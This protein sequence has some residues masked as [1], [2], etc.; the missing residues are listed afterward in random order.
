MKH[1]LF[2]IACLVCLIG[3]A[4]KKDIYLGT[5]M[6]PI[7]KSDYQ[8]K[9]KEPHFQLTYELDSAV[10]H[11]KT[12]RTVEG[13]I[14]KNQLDFI[15]NGL[16]INSERTLDVLSTLVV[17]YYPGDDKCNKGRYKHMIDPLGYNFQKEIKKQKHVEVFYVA[18]SKAEKKPKKNQLQW[19]EDYKATIESLFFHF[20]Y[21][22]G[23]FV[24]INPSGTFLSFKGEYGLQQISSILENHP[25]F[26]QS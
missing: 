17:L 21:P 4:Q 25:S 5:D 22:C 9:E 11:V 12:R 10:V 13:S 18:K 14:T 7:T 2:F 26:K 15:R 19:Q 24:I 16:A 6:R 20:H 1:F 8:K 23:S 3:N